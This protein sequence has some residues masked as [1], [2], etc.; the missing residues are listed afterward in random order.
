MKTRFKHL[1]VIGA[2]I[3]FVTA[4]V[5]MFAAPDDRLSVKKA[6]ELI[7][8]IAGANMAK[9]R[10]VIKEVVGGVNGDMIVDAQIETSFRMT[11]DNGDWRI[12]EIRLGDRQWESFELIEEAIAREKI[13]RTTL[14]LE[15]LAK[16]LTAY[17]NKRGRFAETEDFA[18]L[19]DFLSPI[20]IN[21]PPRFDLWGKEFTYRGTATNYRLISSGP[22][23]KSGTKDD[24]VIE[25]GVIRSMTE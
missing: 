9:D 19:L 1:G 20:Y 13:R 7:Q 25:N 4:S 12:A 18:Q 6:R 5:L 17:Q 10:V 16:A 24:L 3:G 15:Q 14:L 8:Q 23:R 21:R 11:R 2:G 22:D